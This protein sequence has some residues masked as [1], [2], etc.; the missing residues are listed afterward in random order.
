LRDAG[1]RTVFDLLSVGKEKGC[2]DMSKLSKVSE[3][4]LSTTFESFSNDPD[5]SALTDV[6]EKLIKL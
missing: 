5:I 2:A 3:E 1:I 6:R 4:R